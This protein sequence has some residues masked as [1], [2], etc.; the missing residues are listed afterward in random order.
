MLAFLLKRNDSR[1]VS[2]QSVPLPRGT[3]FENISSGKLTKPA[4]IQVE[5]MAIIRILLEI[6][7]SFIGKTTAT[8]LSIA[9]HTKLWVDTRKDVVL[10]KMCN[11]HKIDPRIPVTYQ[12]FEEVTNSVTL[13]GSIIRGKTK[14]DKAMFTMK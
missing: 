6:S 13:T 12:C 11:L 9:I 5:T 7:P 10:A 14:S 8:N 4:Q 3:S 2:A 1:F